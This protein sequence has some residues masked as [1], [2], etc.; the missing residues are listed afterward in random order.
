MTD[1]KLHHYV[2]Q[3]YLRR[4]VDEEGRL[5]V[6]DR[7][8]DRVFPSG[9]PSVAAET[10]FYF[11]DELAAHGHDPLAMER[12]LGDLEQ[13]VAMITGQWIEWIRAGDLGN[14][15]EVPPVNREIISLFIAVQYFRTE[16]ARSVLTSF[17]E[18]VGY[19]PE[20]DEDRRAL[21]AEMLWSENGVVRMVADRVE[22]ST[23]VFGRN[24][25]DVPFTTSDNPVAFRTGDN[26]MWLKTAFM[27]AGT[28][29][30]YPLAPDV[31]MYCYPDEEPWNK[32][33]L[34][35]F[36]CTVSP[37]TFTDELVESENMA[38]VFMASRFVFSNRPTF[39]MEREF[40]KTVGTDTY[41]P[42]GMRLFDD[43]DSS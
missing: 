27:G 42:P 1:P 36:D 4:F 35:R 15:V 6:W 21:H 40:A 25:T 34:K 26:R 19:V 43:D 38:H 12:Q 18:T 9:P 11:L 29:V 22:R 23:W 10:N 32:P 17:A 33:G 2:P 13:D 31:V 39:D 28:Y 41:A 37:V 16:D 8:R 20:S 30:V 14:S 5:W 24:N 3:F 7:D